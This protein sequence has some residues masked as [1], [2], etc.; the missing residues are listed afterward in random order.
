VVRRRLGGRL[1]VELARP[2]FTTGEGEQLAVVL[3]G[4]VPPPPA[5]RRYVTEVAKDPTFFTMARPDRW[6]GAAAFDGTPA[7]VALPEAGTDVVVL[8][9]DVLQH[10][11]AWAADVPMPGVDAGSYRPFVRL[12]VA[13]YQRDSLPGL[14]LSP[15][16][17]APLVQALPDRTL[18]VDTR[19]AGQVSV[20]LEGHGPRAGGPNRVDVVVERLVSPAAAGAGPTATAL[21]AEPPPGVAAWVGMA[22][23]S[24]EL[25]QPVVVPRAADAGPLRLRVREIERPAPVATP[26]STPDELGERVV[27]TDLV[28]LP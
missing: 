2:W 4:T 15:V 24:A 13:R 22:V 17:L 1:R 23:S 25:G 10:D 16:V 20:S 26:A 12:A 8:P 7:T 9:Y 18:T 14:E 19:A 5:L 11:G 3:T 21:A 27:F 6:P 28:A